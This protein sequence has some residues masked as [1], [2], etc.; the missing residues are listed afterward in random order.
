MQPAEEPLLRAR[1]SAGPA[2]SLGRALSLC[3]EADKREFQ[4]AAA[5]LTSSRSASGAEGAFGRLR[6]RTLRR[7]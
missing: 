1:V 2:P 6:V 7:S 3:L 5:R 4:R